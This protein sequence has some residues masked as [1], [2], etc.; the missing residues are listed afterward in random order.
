M[1]ILSLANSDDTKVLS[2]SGLVVGK[3][4]TPDEEDFEEVPLLVLEKKSVISL[5]PVENNNLINWI[6]YFS[7]QLP[8]RQIKAA[9][10][11]HD[12]FRIS[13]V[14]IPVTHLL[15]HSTGHLNPGGG[16]ERA[17]ETLNTKHFKNDCKPLK[18]LVNTFKTLFV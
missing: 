8:R 14:V 2:W 13:K 17:F 9:D 1:S 5:H 11:S 7:A 15:T 10:E 4:C 16:G 18:A 6:K 12:V 3:T